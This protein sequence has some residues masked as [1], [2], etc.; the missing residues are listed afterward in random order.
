MPKELCWVC[1]WVSF[2]G[3]M[4]LNMCILDNYT[5]SRDSLDGGNLAPSRV[6]KSK[7]LTRFRVEGLGLGFRVIAGAYRP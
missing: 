3:A 5:T 1:I 6:L 2:W 4:V 7:A